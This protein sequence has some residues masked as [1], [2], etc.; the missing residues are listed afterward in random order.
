MRGVAAEVRASGSPAVAIGLLVVGALFATLWAV[1]DTPQAGLVLLPIVPV[2]IRLAAVR[3]ET[4][5]DRLVARNF[6][7]SWAVKRSD[8]VAF[9]VEDLVDLASRSERQRTV[10]VHLRDGTSRRLAATKRD[11]FKLFPYRPRRNARNEADD[12]CV[13]L[14]EWLHAGP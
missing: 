8:I 1:S 9:V 3:V 11:Y 13:R 2:S 6:W 5:D 12:I 14:N 10:Y 7:S 4:S